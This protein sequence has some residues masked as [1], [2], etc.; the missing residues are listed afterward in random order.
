MD[1]AQLSRHLG[2]RCLYP[3]QGQ[4]K[5][6]RIPRDTPARVGGSATQGEGSHARSENGTGHRGDWLAGD[7]GLPHQLA[8]T[9]RDPVTL[10]DRAAPLS[11]RR[12][13]IPARQ[14]RGESQSKRRSVTLPF[15]G[16]IPHTPKEGG[17]E[18]WYLSET[19]LHDCSSDWRSLRSS[20]SICLPFRG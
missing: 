13:P 7:W 12:R 5:P 1:A 14:R 11:T 6:T 15:T 2:L 8:G 19:G 4:L 10:Q 20:M 17:E 3:E 9:R 16:L 18:Q